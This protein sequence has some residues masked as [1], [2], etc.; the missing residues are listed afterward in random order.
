[1]RAF[2]RILLAVLLAGAFAGA[3]PRPAG[4]SGSWPRSSLCGNSP[5][6]WPA[7][8]ERP[9]CFFRPGRGSTPGSPGPATSAA[10]PNATFSCSSAPGWNPGSRTC[11]RPF[12][13][14]ESGPSRPP[15]AWPWPPLPRVRP[16]NTAMS[17]TTAPS[18]RMSG[19]TSSSTSRSSAGSPR[20]WPGSIPAGRPIFAANAEALSGRLRKLDAAFREGL[21]GCRGR[22]LVLAGHGAFGYL[23]RRYGLVQTALY[24]LSPDAQPKPKDLMKAV[25]FCRAKGLKTVFFEN[26]VPPDLAKAL[27]REIGG[28]VLVLHAGSQ[29]DPRAAGEGRRL[30]R[31]HGGG[32]G[33]SQR[34]AG[35]PV[36]P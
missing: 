8:G 26:S 20:S 28:R 30:L 2:G 6:P 1:M 18:T 17:T 11:S 29:P 13:R 19:S 24:G 10:W 21:A 5:R 31:A 33:P 12:R 7:T 15:P 32:P 3:A 35:L 25:D 34:G 36:R 14:G 4:S 16:T 22:D 9:P 23:A 27:A